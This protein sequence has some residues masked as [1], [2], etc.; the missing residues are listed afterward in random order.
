MAF[1]VAE[2]AGLIRTYEDFSAG[3]IAAG[4]QN[5]IICIEMFFA[6][7]ALR[8]AFPYSIYL[9]QRK[10]DERGQ[11]IALKSIS[12]N[13]RQTMNPKDIVDDAIHSFSR[14]YQQYE[15]AQA[16]RPSTESTA[17]PSTFTS[18]NSTVVDSLDSV[19]SMKVTVL[20]GH[21]YRYDSEKA[22]LLESDD[23]F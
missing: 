18:Y 15:N 2:K 6:A 5:F 16:V 8:Y 12:K 1:A 4:Y 11:G 19:G 13:L 20:D 17:L 22:T 23:D 14:S 10:L 9:H 3:T 7:I 21:G